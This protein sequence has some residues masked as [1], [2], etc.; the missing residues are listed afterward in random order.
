MRTPTRP[1]A[2]WP[3]PRRLESEIVAFERADSISPPPRGAI[4]AVGSSSIRF[5][6]DRIH[7]DLAPSAIVPRGFGGSTMRDV[8]HYLDRLVLRCRPHAVLLYE[9]DNDIND[10]VSAEELRATFDTLVARI[11]DAKP[12]MILYVISIKPSPARW[13]KWPEME[14]ANRLLREA[15]AADSRLVYIDV[16]EPM[17]DARSGRPRAE[18]FGPDSLH[19]NASGYEVWKEVVGETLRIAR[20]QAAGRVRDILRRRSPV[21]LPPARDSM[22]A[23]PRRAP[24]RRWRTSAPSA[25]RR[26]RTP[27]PP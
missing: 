24:R 20:E 22:R 13:A 1:A 10:G 26:R 15:S 19:M 12:S 14:R 2:P 11:H 18:L 8:L 27:P 5:W 17:L 6:H 7:G 3:D 25:R 21:S 4:V 9:G 23:R 16:A